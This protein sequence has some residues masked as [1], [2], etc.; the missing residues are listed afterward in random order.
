MHCKCI[1]PASYPPRVEIFG[2]R[3]SG[4]TA[5]REWGWDAK[6]FLGPQGRRFHQPGA[7]A[8]SQALSRQFLLYQKPQCVAGLGLFTAQRSLLEVWKLSSEYISVMKKTIALAFTPGIWLKI[9]HKT[10]S[11][12]EPE[13]E[14]GQAALRCV[15]RGPGRGAAAFKGWKCLFV[16]VCL[17]SH[18]RNP[19]IR[20][21]CKVAPKGLFFS[22]FQGVCT[23]ALITDSDLSG[24]PDKKDNC[25]R[26]TSC[27]DQN[28]LKSENT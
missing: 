27:G 20:L 16:S 3:A 14:L 25:Y 6:K 23:H 9:H 12:C 24:R 21:T 18:W 11:P 19:F 7:T 28:M 26:P 5:S 4:K 10:G 15:F 1:L 22:I 13:T 17:P 2:V 8:A